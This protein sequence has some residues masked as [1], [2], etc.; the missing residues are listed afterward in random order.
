MGNSR[1]R[2]IVA[3]AM[4]SLQTGCAMTEPAN[5]FVRQSWRL[6]KPNPNGYQDPTENFTDEWSGVGQEARGE[7]PF[8]TDPDSWWQKYVMSGKA[9]A[10]ERNLGIK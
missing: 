2:F 10:I 1:L 7:R 5:K 4:I 3:L 6:F 8:D 9:R